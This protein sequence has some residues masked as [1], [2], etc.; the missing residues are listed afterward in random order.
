[1]TQPNPQ[2]PK[3]Q[4]G[5]VMTQ[6]INTMV[7]FGQNTLKPGAQ[8]PEIHVEG[9]TQPFPLVGD[10]HTG[11]RSS[12]R[13]ITIR[14]ETV[15][16]NHFL[17]RKDPDSNRHFV[18]Q[19]DKSSNGIYVNNR[20]VK[21]FSLRNGDTVHLAPPELAQAVKLTYRYTPPIWVQIIRYGLIGSGGFIG[22]LCLLFAWQWSQYPLNPLPSGVT[23]PVVIF[24]GDGETAINP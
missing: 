19:D 8:V 21:S 3:T 6:A 11:G 5:R 20:K 12:S 22:F 17:L 4:I 14:N 1:M 15:S 16:A 10:R 2:P 18:I 24:S 9:Q 13:D 7:S 23:G